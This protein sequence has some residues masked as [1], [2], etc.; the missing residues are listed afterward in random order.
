MV[1]TFGI[2]GCARDTK[3]TATQSSVADIYRV[4]LDTSRGPILIDVD[5]SLAPNGAKR[6]ADLVTAHYFDGARFYRVVPG[7][8]VQWG[9]AATPALTKKWDT[10]IPDD[11]VKGSNTRGTVT[12]AATGQPNSR[13]T[14]LF[15]NLGDNTRLDAMG[16]APIGHVE[17]GMQAVDSIY[18]GYGEQ[19]D[20]SLIQRQGN[21][22][23]QKAF[24]RLDY[25]RTAH[26]VNGTRLVGH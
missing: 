14:H 25:I 21:A 13:T 24:P 3:Q 7:F 17:S 6:F 11:P 19:P 5:R 18:S 4:V 10:T 9:A 16:F 8:V 20:Q 2:A 23:L 15:I 12:F 1:L 26:L 22:Y